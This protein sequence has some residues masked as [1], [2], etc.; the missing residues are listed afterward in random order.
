[1]SLE[2]YKRVVIH[3]GQHIARELT[4]GNTC[5]L[6]DLADAIDSCWRANLF[7]DNHNLTPDGIELQNA[8]LNDM[9]TTLDMTG[10][11]HTL[12]HGCFALSVI[13]SLLPD[14]APYNIHILC[15]PPKQSRSKEPFFMNLG[16]QE[17]PESRRINRL[18]AQIT[19]HINQGL[20]PSEL[21]QKLSLDRYGTTTL[22]MALRRATGC[23]LQDVKILSEFWNYGNIT[24]PDVFDIEAWKLFR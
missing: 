1:M 10:T 12:P 19:Q 7:G 4:S 3:T 11:L 2:A 8:A 13:L 20:R 17:T 14:L 22:I 15:I 23:G 9:R 16:L 24:D 18:A 6:G 21:V 5:T